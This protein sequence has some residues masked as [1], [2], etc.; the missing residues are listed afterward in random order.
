M[1]KLSYPKSASAESTT[2]LVVGHIPIAAWHRLWRL[3]QCYGTPIPELVAR[4]VDEYLSRAEMPEVAPASRSR[5]ERIDQV[6][7]MRRE[8][9]TLEQIGQFHGFTREY[10]R[11]LLKAA[12][13]AGRLPAT[14]KTPKPDRVFFQIDMTGQKFN[15]LTVLSYAGHG[16]WNVK[17]DCGTEKAVSGRN[18]RSGRTGSCG[19]LAR[20][21]MRDLGRSGLGRKSRKYSAEDRAKIMAATGRGE[22]EILAREFG[23]TTKGLHNQRSLW[24]RQSAASEVR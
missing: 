14:P 9:K 5:Q 19:C 8:G 6:V 7:S 1:T 3:R 11:Q 22:T 20:E 10:A 12:G 17:C 15:R 13:V 2:K 21:H 4:A 18:I 16:K 24:R 23:I